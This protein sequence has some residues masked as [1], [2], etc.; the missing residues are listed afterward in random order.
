MKTVLMFVFLIVPFGGSNAQEKEKPAAPPDS[1]SGV[2]SD[3]A[4]MTVEELKSFTRKQAVYDSQGKRDPFGSLAPKEVEEGKKIKGL[5]NYEKVVLS[6]IVRTGDDKYALVI[7]ADKFGHV[8]RE[9]YMVYGGYVTAITEDKVYLHIVKYGRAM[10]I[11]LSLESSKS[12]VVAEEDGETVVRRPGINI[13]YEPSTQ[14]RREIEI[15]DVVVPSLH[16]KTLDEV[17]FDSNGSFPDIDDTEDKTGSDEV[18]A[19]SLFNPP[20]DSWIKLPFEMEWTSV[21]E[22]GISYTIM[23][24]DDPDFSAPHSV[25]EQVHTSSYLL[26]EDMNLPVD[27]QLFWKVVAVDESGNEY[28]CRQTS[29]SFKITGNK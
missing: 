5:L 2:R 16:T 25:M 24:D 21:A 8:L 20:D 12:T 9:G 13:Y 1:S 29:M 11:I 28:P 22:K 15:Q 26:V 14:S 18:Q 6:G 27:R 10:T 23:I 3:A 7:D 17:W 19:F 4:G